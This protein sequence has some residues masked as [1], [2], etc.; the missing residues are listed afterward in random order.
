MAR[1]AEAHF[2]Y[3][4]CSLPV[5]EPVKERALDRHHWCHNHI[6]PYYV[7]RCLVCLLLPM[8]A[9]H[10]AAFAKQ[11]AEASLL[12]GDWRKISALKNPE[13]GELRQKSVVQIPDHPSPHVLPQP[14]GLGKLVWSKGS[15]ARAQGVLGVGVC[16][17]IRGIKLFA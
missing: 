7:R 16:P 10:Q 11:C 5:W 1:M 17:P 4:R 2:I 13:I 15:P 9:D 14:S 6:K 8:L 3:C 12:G